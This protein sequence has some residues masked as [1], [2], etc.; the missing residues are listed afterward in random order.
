[1]TWT[2]PGH[3]WAGLFAL[4]VGGLLGLLVP[5]LIA[6]LPEPAPEPN[7]ETD[8]V[9]PGL[10]PAP[11]K[12]PYVAIAALPGLAWRCAIAT[13][14]VAGVVGLSTGWHGALVYLVPL[15][16]IGV[17]L[18]LIDWRTTLLPTRI[19]A[20]TYGLV[21]AGIVVAG[22][23]DG[24]RHAVI[25][26]VLGWVALGGF[27]LLQWLVYPPAM[28][29][30]DVRLS[31]VLGLALGYLGWAPVVVGGMAAFFLGGIIGTVLSRLSVVDR[32]R[33]PFGPF[34]LAGALVGIAVGP[35]VATSLGY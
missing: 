25:R 8:V 29:Y 14:L 16:P 15:A 20:P 4:V 26:A 23:L 3:P 32:K 28:G 7:P 21:V 34:M 2:D 17:A 18:T 13:A 31:G 1:M 22:V 30:G 10:P 9:A 35:W 19:I 33:Y 27:Y 6:V 5:R 24:D 11:P 12:E